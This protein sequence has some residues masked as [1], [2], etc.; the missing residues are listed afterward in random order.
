MLALLLLA[1]TSFGRSYVVHSC[2]LPDGRPAPI[3]GWRST[4]WSN[5]VWFDNAC[6]RGGAL[7]AGLAGIAQPANQSDIGW[8]FESGDAPIRSYRIVRSGAPRGWNG[9]VSM[10][11]FSSDNVNHPGTG[12][13][14]DYCAA[15]RGC[16]GVS[17]LLSRNSATIPEQSRAWYFTLGCGGATGVACALAAGNS[18]FGSLQIDSARFELDDSELPTA[19]SVAGSL[20]QSGA[21]SGNLHFEARDRISGVRRATIE[22]DGV[23][24]TETRPDANGGRCSEIGQA[25]GLPDFTYRRPCPERAQVELS[26]P[27]GALPPGTHSLRAR[28]YDAAGNGLTVLGPREVSVA[29]VSATAAARLIPDRGDGLTARYG[30][31][32]RLGGELTTRAGA[33]IAGATIELT[34]SAPAAARSRRVVSVVTDAAGRYSLTTV[35]RSSRSISLLHRASGAV[36]DQR[37]TVRGP[38][39]L[40]AKRRRVA[41]L[42]RM[43]LR[44]SIPTERIKRR[45]TVAIKV[46]S[47]RGWRTIGLARSD[48]NGRF[49]FNYRFR[50]TRSASFVFR[51]VAVDSSDLPIAPQ[52]SNRVRIRVG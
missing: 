26:L 11:L 1:P 15:Y 49:A 50:R 24:V 10:V 30:R 35:A 42:G 22:L 38:L 23:V 6:A 32:V 46:R 21:T 20:V 28:V 17:G 4:G 48:R 43:Q 13:V 33:P 36:A 5:Y 12:T 39:R 14:V 31:R 29:G 44:G 47:G 51:A 37:L 2:K 34:M 27:Q 3:D 45:A 40:A 18:D 16:A 7:S 41:P 25:G 9:A 19:S 52:P 8:G